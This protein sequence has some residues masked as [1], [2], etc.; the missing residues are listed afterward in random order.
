MDVSTEKA[1]KKLK[2]SYPFIGSW[3]RKKG[4]VKL[5]GTKE[6][7][8]VKPLLEA[9]KDKSEKVREAVRDSLHSLEGRARDYLCSLWE[10]GR[11]KELED[12]ILRCRYLASEPP[13]LAAKTSLLTGRKLEIDL[14]EE[15]LNNC[16][17]DPDSRIMKGMARHLIELKGNEAY[18]IL[19]DFVKDAPES[20]VLT[21]LKDEKWLPEEPVEK[22]LFYFLVN[23]L[24]SYFD[25][26]FDQ[27][28]LMAFY[29]T[30]KEEMKKAI[31][32]R[33]MKSGD[34]R[35]ISIIRREGRKRK[36]THDEV[37]LQKGLL[38][39]SRRFEELFRLLPYTELSQGRE[40][41]NA[42]KDKAWNHPDPRLRELQT[43]LE[44]F[45]QSMKSYEEEDNL[46]IRANTLLEDFRPM[47]IGSLSAPEDDKTLID[48]SNDSNDFRKRSSA[49][50]Y[51]AEKGSPLLKDFANR[52]CKDPYWQVRMSSA[53]A[54]YIKPGTLTN[55][56]RALLEKDHVYYVRAALINIT[57]GRLEDMAV[58]DIEF[59]HGKRISSSPDRKPE[60]P[61]DF[62]S[63]IRG[64]ISTYEREY[65][66][67]LA[68]FFKTDVAVS[69]EVFF[70]ME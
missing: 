19:W 54:E 36:Y 12:I 55:E 4:A 50:I 65:L 40:I 45:F 22:A 39:K 51:L 23:D 69:E 3:I 17:C 58:K 44:A 68:E 34:S 56:N 13:L 52:A 61:D 53:M 14:S 8:A 7:E 48:W 1:I 67:L 63:L 28:F 60:K 38:I 31:F 35:L 47:F 18:Q 25:I 70:E 21:L 24:I 62:L 32:S 2:C 64:F 26:D 10:K 20:Y 27:S 41:I 6:K 43:K 37:N 15:I 29:E 11:E 59:L 9:L 16:L 42:L 57:L 49:I 5:K 33:V 46:P 30:C 66:L